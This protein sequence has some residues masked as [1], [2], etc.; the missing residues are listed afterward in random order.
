MAAAGRSLNLIKIFPAA[1][2]GPLT[3]ME[4]KVAFLR[5]ASNR[6]ITH[7]NVFAINNLRHPLRS[8][9]VI[10]GFLERPNK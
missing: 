7:N 4:R 9:A 6:V 3:A 8:T 1:D 5:R 2:A 10:G